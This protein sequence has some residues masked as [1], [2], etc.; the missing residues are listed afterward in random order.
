MRWSRQANA[1]NVCARR[2]G[3]ARTRA[4]RTAVCP[5]SRNRH[6]RCRLPQP[7]VAMRPRPVRRRAQAKDRPATSV[8]AGVLTRSRRVGGRTTVG[9]EYQQSISS[10]TRV[11]GTVLGERSRQDETCGQGRLGGLQASCR[12]G[13]APHAWLCEPAEKVRIT[14][15]IQ[16]GMGG[17]QSCGVQGLGGVP[18][19]AF[20]LIYEPGFVQ[21]PPL[22]ILLGRPPTEKAS[23]LSS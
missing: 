14:R 19:D 12:R 9:A 8:R 21:A 11:C 17:R 13:R 16:E 5:T 4:G 2:T 1:W 10:C 18:S 20:Q 3:C 15:S 23:L 7:P 22:E 6:M